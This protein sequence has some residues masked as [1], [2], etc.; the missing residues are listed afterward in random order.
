MD[1]LGFP[2][3]IVLGD[4]VNQIHEHVMVNKAL[5]QEEP[6]SGT[7]KGQEIDLHKNEPY[8]HVVV[9]VGCTSEMW[10]PGWMSNRY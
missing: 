1:M 8:S 7:R 5:G 6:L 2:L 4:R 10:F 9:H 3:V